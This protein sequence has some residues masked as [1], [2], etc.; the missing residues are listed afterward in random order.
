M[1]S[2]SSKWIMNWSG[3][4]D[5]SLALHSLLSQ[6]FSPTYLFTTLSEYKRISMHGVSEDLLDQQA[7]LLGLK[8]NKLYLP[9]NCSMEKY[10]SLMREQWQLFTERGVKQSVFG[11]IFLEDLRQ[12]RDEKARDIGVENIYPLWKRDTKELAK[13]FVNKGF[14]AVVVAVDGSKLDKSFVGRELDLDFL[15]D[16]PKTVDPCGENGE[17]H[18]FVYDGPIFKSKVNFE[19]KEKVEKYYK[20][21]QSDN[22][23]AEEKAFYFQEVV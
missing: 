20:V 15:A 12:Y 22:N 19:R 13:E 2:A 17:F 21:N 3:G 9:E 23:K 8:L 18:S 7:S 10:S 11:D 4:K 14:K 1:I 5:S 6:G 16:L